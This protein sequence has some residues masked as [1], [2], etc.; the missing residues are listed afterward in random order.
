MAR[1]FLSYAKED[2][3]SAHDLAG[4][5]RS[6]HIDFYMWEDPNE[7]GSEFV[8]TIE[9]ELAKADGFL[10]L[11]S[12]AYLAAPWCK[13]ERSMALRRESYLR[14]VLAEEF[15]FIFVLQVGELDPSKIDFLGGYDR[16]DFRPANRASG[17]SEALNRLRNVSSVDSTAS[18]PAIADLARFRNRDQELSLVE[19]NLRNLAGDHFWLILGP[20]QL[21]KSWFLQ[22]LHFR[23]EGLDQHWAVYLYDVRDDDADVRADATQL[24]AHL[25]GRSLQ[26]PTAAAQLVR[27]V[28]LDICSS[29]KP[30]LCLLDSAELIT[31]D[32]VEQ[33][34]LY[35]GQIRGYV[36][37]SPTAD[38]VHFAFV[39]ASRTDEDWQGVDP[40]PFPRP[41]SL[42]QFS[43]NT[44][45]TALFEATASRRL[46]PNERRRYAADIRSLSEG[47]PALLTLSLDWL[48]KWE[49]MYIQELAS[50]ETFEQVAHPY[51]ER[52][53][54]STRS[55][56]PHGSR[57]W[58]REVDALRAA[59]RL[60]ARYRI[61]TESHLT[62]HVAVNPLLSEELSKCNWGERELWQVV[63]QT[64]LLQRPMDE[65]WEAIDPA[66]RRLLHRYYYSSTADQ[67]TAHDEAREFY[68]SWAYPGKEHGVALTE[69]LWHETCRLALIGE[70][71]IRPDLLL[72]A[73]RF[74]QRFH[75]MIA[76]HR[77]GSAHSP[78]RM[79][80]YAVKRLKADDELQLALNPYPGLFSEII[81]LV[82]RSEGGG[83]GAE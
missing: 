1:F 65:L 54:L 31:E 79:I 58:S 25:F 22:E 21:G 7:R 70:G 59:L 64:A 35:L 61:L 5:L 26:S 28:S 18:E 75:A 69:C 48:R 19:D 46:G 16:F 9:R 71:S 62:H 47:L 15:Q 68:E 57:N 52:T 73:R 24:L 33:L 67:V 53:I 76:E 13:R 2:R 74:A 49:F 60:L 40:P 30:T 39:C 80:R 27:D 17:A 20:P 6:N 36:Q 51:I 8:D 56:L 11:V 23:M 34:R 44:V 42:T 12:A 77:N 82:A 78:E 4:V 10:A 14:T 81:R 3:Q 41:L 37:A 29:G 45:H 50:R 66:L 83:T 43:A 38:N 72:A 55:L 63:S 32:A